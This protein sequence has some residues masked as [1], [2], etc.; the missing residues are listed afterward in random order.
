M[1]EIKLAAE[2]VLDLAEKNGK[3]NVDVLVEREDLLEVNILDGKVE[4]VEQSTSIGL[5]VRVIDNG[6]TGLAST[7][8]L[9][10]ESIEKDNFS[11][12]I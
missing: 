11:P 5:G 1:F 4:K 9:S 8:R 6:R 2:Q 3:K 12:K 10:Y 7:E